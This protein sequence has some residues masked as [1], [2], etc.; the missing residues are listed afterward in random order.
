MININLLGQKKPF[1]L[2]L[3]LGMDLNHLKLKWIILAI[4]LNFS[5]DFFTV[6]IWQENEQQQQQIITEL[7][8]K[9]TK[10]NQEVQSHGDLKK[11]LEAFKDQ[12]RKLQE[13][14]E[15]VDKILK[16]KKNPRQILE[17]LARNLPEDLWFETLE[18]T[19]DD[20]LKVVGRSISYKSIGDFI[21]MANDSPFFGGQLTIT[22]SSTQE[23]TEG[24]YSR[25]VESCVILSEKLA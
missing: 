17:R 19:R 13:R 11:K 7:Q 21:M 3:I 23:E 5:A 22:K 9:L 6:D 8:A 24:I 16:Q 2:P 20:E 1:R 14:S 12:V 15:Q 4:I 18:V 10:I 25:R